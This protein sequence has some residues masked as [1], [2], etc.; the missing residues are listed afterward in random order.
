M[1][2][3][4]TVLVHQDIEAVKRAMHVLITHLSRLVSTPM[5][6]LQ[7]LPHFTNVIQHE[8]RVDI[9]RDCYATLARALQSAHEVRDE[10]LKLDIYNLDPKQEK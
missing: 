9:T 4:V 8:E 6:D 3:K 10:L 5:I 1:D 2:N 7:I